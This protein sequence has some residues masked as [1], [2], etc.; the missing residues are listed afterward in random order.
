MYH[1]KLENVVLIIH[2]NVLLLSYQFEIS[3]LSLMCRGFLAGVQKPTTISAR[4]T[5]QSAMCWEVEIGRDRVQN[6]VDS[7]AE[8]RDR[9]SF[10]H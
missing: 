6:V 10:P 9:P 4:F 5:L 2:C 8:S 1:F 7:S 3:R